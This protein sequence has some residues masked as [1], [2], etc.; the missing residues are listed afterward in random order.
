M[1]RR[2]ERDKLVKVRS[3]WV[4]GIDFQI[5]LASFAVWIFF[6]GDSSELT[7]EPD[8]VEV[9]WLRAAAASTLLDRTLEL[10]SA[11]FGGALGE[12]HRSDVSIL[13]D[14]DRPH[15][16]VASFVVGYIPLLGFIV[17]LDG[18]EGSSCGVV[19]DH[20]FSGGCLDV[21]SEDGWLD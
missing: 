12:D 20:N 2:N 19:V 9:V 7:V 3:N 5:I 14:L 10:D 4:V 15:N 21:R 6:E 11:R 13:V 16:A 1:E 8:I 17:K 18:Q